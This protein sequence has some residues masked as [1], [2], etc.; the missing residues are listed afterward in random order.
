MTML[1][2]FRMVALVEGVTTILLFFV[3]MPAKYLAGY[4]DLVPPVGWAHGMAFLAYLPA[5]VF[6]LWGKGFG[7]SGWLRTFLAAFIP[8]GTFLN[9]PFLKRKENLLVAR[10]GS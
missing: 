8:M 9:D 4:P 7:L 5:M 10:T 6:G 2:L 3:A 1:K